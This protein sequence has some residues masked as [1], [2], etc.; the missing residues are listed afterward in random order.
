MRLR[1]V[2][3]RP[4]LPSRSCTSASLTQLRTTSHMPTGSV[5]FSLTRPLHPIP[6]APANWPSGR[7]NER[8]YRTGRSCR[9]RRQHR[10]Q[11]VREWTPGDPR[12]RYRLPST[13]SCPAAVRTSRVA[14]QL[15]DECRASPDGGQLCGCT[16]CAGALVAELTIFGSTRRLRDAESGAPAPACGLG[17]SRPAGRGRVWAGGEL[18]GGAGGAAGHDSR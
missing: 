7:S 1:F 6:A 8:A 2:K 18:A 9:G 15:A 5:M 16:N 14:E 10:L 17:R 11:C 4:E 3:P 13:T 12:R